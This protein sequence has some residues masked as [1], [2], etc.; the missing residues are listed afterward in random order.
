[1]SQSSE[2]T[3][4][5]VT[6][7]SAGGN[8][9]TK[10]IVYAATCK[11]CVKN[12]VYT[13]KSIIETRK[14]ISGHRAKY[15]A[16]LKAYRKDSTLVLNPEDVEDESILGA[17]LFSVHKITDIS[18]FDECF[19]FDI[20]SKCNP[21]NLKTTEQYYIDKLNTRRPFGLN[22]INSVSGS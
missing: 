17:H 1:M 18:A 15:N 20:L 22:Q 2:V 9:K 14:R 7:K 6:I 3:N 11:L 21:S 5:D 16:I 4:N 13:G 10:H 12:N 19:K 8:C